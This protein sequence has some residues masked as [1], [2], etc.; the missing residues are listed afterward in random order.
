MSTSGAEQ[1]S[2]VPPTP[3]SSPGGV[4][5]PQSYPNSVSSSP[6]AVSSD[7]DLSS[8]QTTFTNL[9]FT[10]I[11]QPSTTFTSSSQTVVTSTISTTVHLPSS[12][13]L[14]AAQVQPVCIGD[15]IDAL[16]DG[17]LAV[18]LLPTAVGLLL[19][20]RVTVLLD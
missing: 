8:G 4:P 16:A 2:A 9:V 13:P 12:S 14:S 11:T 17:A 3:T 20:V 10:T 18:V 7:S 19:W 1:A 5:D 6:G 15:G